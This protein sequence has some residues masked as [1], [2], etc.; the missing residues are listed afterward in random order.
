[1]AA[2]AA[3][4][5]AMYLR[6]AAFAERQ[7]TL[8][9]LGLVF[10]S[11]RLLSGL[12]LQLTFAGYGPAFSLF[13]NQGRFVAGGALPFVDYWMEYPPM[14]PWLNVGA[15]LASQL[16]PGETTLWYGT[17]SRW[18][19]VPFDIGGLTV[20]YLIAR[21]LNPEAIALRSVLLYVMTFVTLYVPL[22]WFDAMP[23]F[24]LLLTILLTLRGNPTGTGIAA[25]L[26]FLTKPIP[27]LALPTAWMRMS[28]RGARTR[29]AV[30]AVAAIAIPIA[31]LVFANP[32]LNLAYLSNLLNRSSW[33]TIW[34]L[35]DGYHSYGSVVPLEARFDPTSAAWQAHTG[36]GGYE[37]WSTIAFGLLALGLWTR[38]IN[39]QD[40]RR[41][42]AFVGLT[43]CLFALWSRGYSPQWAINFIPFV[44]L[45]LPNVRGAV[46]LL[47]LGV[48]LVAEWPAAFTLF[49]DQ[50]WYLDAII[51]WRT[52]LTAVL[53]FELGTM[54]FVSES[55]VARWRKIAPVALLTLLAAAGVIFVRAGRGYLRAQLANEPLRATVETLRSETGPQSGLI[56]REIDV[57][58]QLAPYLPQ[59][60]QHWLPDPDSWQAQQLPAF[61][62]QHPDLWYVE[63]FDDETGHD[64]SVESWLSQ[65]Y[66]KASLVWI[67]GARVARFVA[68]EVDTVEP[69]DVYFGQ[70]IRL[71]GYGTRRQGRYL[72]IALIWENLATAEL[73]LKT[74]V[75]VWDNADN[76]IAQNDQYPVGGFQPPNTWEPES[77]VRDLHGLLLPVNA[78]GPFRIRL[79]W[80]DPATGER[81]AIQSPPDALGNEMFEIEIP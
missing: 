42:V 20:L 19:L 39:W 67:E 49:A 38:R 65:R 63:P 34:A 6:L 45:L 10:G 81:L 50:Q 18:A 28:A 73:P 76:L 16:I 41:A 79:G 57:C 33:E 26:G 62:E 11:T 74:F 51:V 78:A 53:T 64:L 14:F 75:H 25:G 30:A 29:L 46:Y 80:Y 12:F 15:Y 44:A 71:A 58:E 40:N 24:W 72:N 21:R 17:L 68:M 56:C 22:G 54:V 61:A 3:S 5:E 9:A 43:W 2:L 66:G 48:A 69:A 36:A 47:L 23:L 31:P 1:M 52:A 13:M 55:A 32:T 8:L 59:L 27:L 70:T 35:L 60:D 77:T 4:I 7:S 37:P